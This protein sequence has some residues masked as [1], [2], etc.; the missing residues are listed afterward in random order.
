MTMRHGLEHT[1]K[2]T[3][4]RLRLDRVLRESPCRSL[5]VL[6]PAGQGRVCRRVE[7]PIDND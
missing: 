1:R 2:A 4:V 3:P 6:Q 7:G 5:G